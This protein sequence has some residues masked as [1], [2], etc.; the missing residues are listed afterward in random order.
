MAEAA[1]A[2]SATFLDFVPDITDG[3]S[4]FELILLALRGSHPP[5]IFP[6]HVED[7][8][9]NPCSS[10]VDFPIPRSLSR[11]VEICSLCRFTEYHSGNLNQY[12]GVNSY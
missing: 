3:C 10:D 2:L 7:P 8:A 11:F 6:D 12:V 1:I 9:D 4:L 5:G